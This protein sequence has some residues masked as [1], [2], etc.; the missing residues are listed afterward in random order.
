M[1]VQRM[2]GPDPWVGCVVGCETGVAVVQ[3][4]RGEVRATYSGRMLGRIARDRDSAARAGD[5]VVLRCWP[6]D[7]VTIEDVPPRAVRCAEV[8]ELHPPR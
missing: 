8:I 5:W 1:S 6:D 7:K 2:S 4:D 3:T